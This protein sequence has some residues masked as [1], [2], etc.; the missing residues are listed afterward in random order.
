MRVLLLVFFSIPCFA[1]ELLVRGRYVRA[2]GMGNVHSMFAE[3]ENALIYNPAALSRISGINFTIM[4]PMG[5]LNG[6]DKIE[7]YS[8]ALDADSYVETLRTFYGE[9][10]YLAGG[11]KS[12]FFTKHFA[13]SLYGD[14]EMSIFL[15]DPAFP[16]MNVRY[17]IDYGVNFGFSF[18]LFEF[19]EFGLGARTITRRGGQAPIGI[20]T[21]ESLDNDDVVEALDLRGNGY[22]FDVGFLFQVPTGM[23]P[24]VSLVYHNVGGVSFSDDTGNGA[25]PSIPAYMVAGFGVEIDSTLVTIRPGFEYTHINFTEE[26][27]GKKINLG[28]EIEFPLFELRAGLHQGYYTLGAGVDLKFI[29]IDAATYGVELGEYPGQLEDRRFM[30]QLTMG[31]G[32]D[33]GMNFQGFGGINQKRLKQRR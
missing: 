12:S 17:Q 3:N 30:L 2:L 11:M 9:Q 25:P 16:T 8:D 18:P 6:I 7:E 33:L 29:R 27:D 32:F 21:L 26:Q 20:D 23:K 1:D 5:G 10:V 28:V 13:V 24:L 31:L 14:S 4:D 15:E 19:L 22:G